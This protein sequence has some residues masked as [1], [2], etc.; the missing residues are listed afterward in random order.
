MSKQQNYHADLS[1]SPS[2]LKL[3]DT[4]SPVSSSSPKAVNKATHRVDMATHAFMLARRYQLD[5]YEVNLVLKELQMVPC[6]LPNG[7]IEVAKFKFFL[8]R[9]F[10]CQ[11][12]PDEISEEAYEEC[13]AHD[14]P[15]D[16]DKFLLWYRNNMFAS[17]AS[18]TADR[19]M[20]RNDDII[21][22]VA[23]RHDISLI[24]AGRIKQEFCRFDADGSGEIDFP[25]FCQMMGR[26]MGT[27][28][29]GDIPPD[30]MQ[31]F[32]KEID[33]DGNGT[34]DFEEFTNWYM[35][36]FPDEQS[37]GIQ[38]AFY[39]SYSPDVQRKRFLQEAQRVEQKLLTPAGSRGWS[40]WS[41]G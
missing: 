1:Q 23:R 31:R 17:V 32:W 20:R 29:P 9:V 38:E 41:V 21:A 24:Q 19:H 36:Y 11:Q 27:N 25:E 5:L 14:G 26:L 30:R 6:A 8:Q 34:V 22:S 37:G 13:L 35:K 4:S 10:G 18:M 39:A 33:F 2:K 7:G 28:T 40:A 12:V 3:S 15:L 16:V